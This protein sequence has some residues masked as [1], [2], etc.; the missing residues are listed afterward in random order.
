MIS[1]NGNQPMNNSSS[2]LVTPLFQRNFDL[3]QQVESLSSNR[4]FPSKVIKTNQ[5]RIEEIAN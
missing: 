3:T 4:E 2:N 5:Q 1:I